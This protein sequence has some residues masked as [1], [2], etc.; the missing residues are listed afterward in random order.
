MACL[1]RTAEHG[2]L[3]RLVHLGVRFLTTTPA[4][5]TL[6]RPDPERLYVLLETALTLGLGTVLVAEVDGEVV[7][8]LVYVI[9]PNPI[10]GEAT[11]EEI[12]W[13]VAPEHRTSSIGP[14]LLVA[15]ES[16][17]AANGATTIKMI[18]PAG[19]EV[20]RFYA[21]R[22]YVAVETA[23]A[24][25]VHH[26]LVYPLRVD[27]G[28]RQDREHGAVGRAAD[29]PG[30]TDGA[31]PDGPGRARAHQPADRPADGAAADRDESV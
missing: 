9:L 14:R 26:G 19:S 6:L 24:K 3:E 16:W 15:G 1:I 31:G 2:D 30:A 23:Y 8:G 5:C 28:S 22:G 20:G 7:G 29:I 13:F 4:Y 25:Q 18:A 10:S 21:R 17:C 12:A 27:E 11:A